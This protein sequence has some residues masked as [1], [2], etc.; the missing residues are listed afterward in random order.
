MKQKELIEQKAMQTINAQYVILYTVRTMQCT[1]KELS[2]LSLLSERGYMRVAG[3]RREPTCRSNDILHNANG[4]HLDRVYSG[5]KVIEVTRWG[6]WSFW[7]EATSLKTKPRDHQAQVHSDQMGLVMAR[8]EAGP[9]E[10]RLSLKM[11]K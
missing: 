4:D 6:G 2:N 9:C 5:Q 8:Q 1:Y 11:S 7:S 3:N 10:W